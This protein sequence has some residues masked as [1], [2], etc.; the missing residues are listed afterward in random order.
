MEQLEG[1]FW[2]DKYGHKLEMN[3]AYQDALLYINR[4][5]QS[6]T[7]RT[8]YSTGPDGALRPTSDSP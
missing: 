8:K 6:H 3:A 1:G 4:E 2:V 7:I 5:T